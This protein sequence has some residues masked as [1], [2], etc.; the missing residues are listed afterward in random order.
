MEN[1]VKMVQDKLIKHKSRLSELE[2]IRNLL[3][4]D[5]KQELKQID[6]RKNSICKN[7]L[8]EVKPIDEEILKL[9]KKK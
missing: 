2:H 7:Y 5:L 3:F 6:N 9:R 1:G 8:K 4:I